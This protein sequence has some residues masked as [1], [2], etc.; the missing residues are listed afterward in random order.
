MNT[1]WNKAEKTLR[2][3]AI[4]IGIARSKMN[5]TQEQ[6]ADKFGYSRTTLAKLETG[7]RDIK[8]TEIVELAEKLGV[9]CDFLL[10]RTMATK[11][12]DVIQ[13]MVDR[14]GITEDALKIFQALKENRIKKNDF[15][16]RNMQ[17][18]DD[19]DEFILNHG[20]TDLVEY[21]ERI[22][23]IL[24]LL[25]TTERGRNDSTS[26]THGEYIFE[27][28]YNYFFTENNDEYSKAIYIAQVYAD[29]MEFGK[30][31]KMK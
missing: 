4:N 18:S 12:D 5:L 6:F 9:S 19:L 1:D 14:Y 17:P 8:S 25:F 29:I 2:T 21:G 20:F 31:L 16:H 13:E 15:I 24:N 11:P 26:E 27:I 22:L 7:K 23:K 28:L 30:K 10:G 3:I